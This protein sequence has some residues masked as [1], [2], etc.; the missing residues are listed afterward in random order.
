MFVNNIHIPMHDHHSVGL[1][2]LLLQD[3]EAERAWQMKSSDELPP[4]PPGAVGKG[5][6]L[7]LL[8]SETSH[9]HILRSEKSSRFVVLSESGED[10]WKGS[11]FFPREAGFLY[12]LWWFPKVYTFGG[13]R[14]IAWMSLVLFRKT[15]DSKRSCDDVTWRW[16]N[17]EDRLNHQPY[18]LIFAWAWSETEPE[19]L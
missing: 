11:G 3:L 7:G 18:Q 19:I 2:K 6:M 8:T 17:A 9:E 16:Q 4:L 1:K 12:W 10:S 15:W 5:L 14:K 13:W